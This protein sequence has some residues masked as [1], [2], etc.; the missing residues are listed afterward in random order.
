MHKFIQ[1][2]Y[3]NRLKVWAV[4]LAI[5]FAIVIIQVLNGFFKDERE[6]N[7]NEETTRE[8]CFL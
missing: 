1:F 3:Q 5:I 7:Q 6:N 8:C 4:I 2:Y